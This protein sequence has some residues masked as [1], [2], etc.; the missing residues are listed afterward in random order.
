MGRR[1]RKNTENSDSEN[2]S[3][4]DSSPES[5]RLQNPEFMELMQFDKE[6]EYFEHI[7]SVREEMLEYIEYNALSLCEYMSRD[8]FY[9]FVKNI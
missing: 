3:D 4:N 9:Q 8:D 1:T 5:Q 2:E 6:N 7:F